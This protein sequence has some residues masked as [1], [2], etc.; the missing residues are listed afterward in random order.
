[1]EKKE[2][3][4]YRGIHAEIHL[5]NL[6]H[7]FKEIRRLVGGQ[8]K[9]IPIVKANAYGHGA[10]VVAKTLENLGVD[11]FGV[12]SPEEALELRNSNIQS[13]LLCLGGIF[14]AP[15][16]LFDEQKVVLTLFHEA[17]LE[18]IEKDLSGTTR[19]LK[20]HLKVDTGMGRLGILPEEVDRFLPRLQQCPHIEV[21]GLLTHLACADLQ[22]DGPTQLQYERFQQAAEKFQKTFPQAEVIHLANS[23]AILSGNMA[24]YQWARPGLM[25]YG[26]Y[27]HARF[28]TKAQLKPVMH[29]KTSIMSL[30]KVAAGVPISYGGT[31][32]TKRLTQVAVMAAGYAD[33]YLRSFSNCGEVVI[34]GQR[35]PVIGRVCM[36]HTMIDVT[37]LKQV[38]MGD[39]VT[40]WGETLCAEELA[41]KIDTIAYELFC[42][43]SA[44]VPRI[45]V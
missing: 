45:Y 28:K 36:D 27:P 34:R 23:S 4:S 17:Q 38:A 35:C 9:L 12:A 2:N 30:K 33:G 10:S 43:V 7:N 24:H 41:D 11:G 1:M 14:K 32:V 26:A 13:P 6:A 37:D 16:S 8:V 3:H 20:V 29:F 44:R 5:A 42:A 19:K 25:L 31:F 39:E 22:E 21:Q 40:L 18:R 15:L